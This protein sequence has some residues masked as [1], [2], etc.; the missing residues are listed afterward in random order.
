MWGEGGVWGRSGE[1]EGDVTLRLYI[2]LRSYGS[3]RKLVKLESVQFILDHHTV[4]G[5]AILSARCH[6]MV[7]VPSLNTSHS[8]MYPIATWTFAVGAH[9][10]QP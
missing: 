7:S 3:V 5:A 10:T 6:Q 8:W 9:F 2:S 1:G 4:Y